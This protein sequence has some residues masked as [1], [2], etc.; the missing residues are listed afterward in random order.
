[1][2]TVPSDDVNELLARL[3]GFD[4]QPRARELRA[5]VRGLLR[6]E[7]GDTVLDVGCGAGLSVAE[8]DGDGARTIGLD[9]DARMLDAARRRHPEGEF[10]LAG[11]EALPLADGVARAYRAER[12]FH[13]VPDPARALA[14]AY[15]VLAPGGRV[16]LIGQDWDAFMIESDDP[17]LTR[18]VVH[19][20][21]DAITHPSAPRR[22]PELLRAAGFTGVEAEG[23]LFVFTSDEVLPFLVQLAARVN[24]AGTV[25]E[26]RVQGW[27]AEQ[28]L[29]AAQG[30]LFVGLPFVVVSADRP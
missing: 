14:E 28:R 11:A 7:P 29:R 16:V 18:E 22:Q 24:R 25:A 9:L 21:A 15:R 6:Y 27:L 20:S 30:R 26:E 10:V 17:G 23:A 12:L 13:V 8:I 4:Q 19:A 2:V 3:D 1:M 5:R